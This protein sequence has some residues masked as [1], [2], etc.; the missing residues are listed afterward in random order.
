MHR[1]ELG[2]NNSVDD[3]KVRIGAM[4]FCIAAG[5]IVYGVGQHAN[6]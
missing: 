6:F 2:D 4:W 1:L 3:G 5:D